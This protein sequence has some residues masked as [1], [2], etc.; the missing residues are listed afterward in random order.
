MKKFK[1]E[2]INL[3]K[4]T[5]LGDSK[6]GVTVM[7]SISSSVSLLLCLALISGTNLSINRK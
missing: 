5:Q 3:H 7:T 6:D 1:N 2:G 4:I